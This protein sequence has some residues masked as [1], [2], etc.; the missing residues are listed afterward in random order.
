[1]KL[2]KVPRER[3]PWMEQHFIYGVLGQGNNAE[4]ERRY[5]GRGRGQGG[6]WG[7]ERPCPRQG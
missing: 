6:G 5:G 7:D 3:S 4:M 1:M 2:E